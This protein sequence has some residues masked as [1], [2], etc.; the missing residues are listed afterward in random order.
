VCVR[1]VDLLREVGRAV[2]VAVEV[3]CGYRHEERGT[4]MANMTKGRLW[5]RALSAGLLIGG[6]AAMTL[7]TSAA[8]AGTAP[9]V[10]GSALDDGFVRTQGG[11]HLD[12]I[13]DGGTTRPLDIGGSFGVTSD[14]EAAVLNVTATESTGPGFIT[15]YPAFDQAGHAS[16]GNASNVPTASNVNYTAGQIVANEVTAKLGAGGFVC[17]FTYA[18]THIV[19]DLNGYFIKG[20]NYT[21][22]NPARLVDTRPGYPTF[23]GDFAGGGPRPAGGVLELTVTDRG[24][25]GK[26]AKTVILNVTATESTA[27][28]FVTVYPCKDATTP[29]PTSSNV[30]FVAGQTVP[31]TVISKVS[32]EG[33][34]CL[35]T[36]AATHLVVDLN[37]YFPTIATYTPV[38]PVRLLDTRPGYPTFDT[39]FAGAGK[40]GAGGDLVLPVRGLGV[41][42][43]GGVGAD[44]KAVVVNVT[45]TES[46]GPGFLT[47]YPCDTALTEVSNLNY[48]AGTNV[49]NTVFAKVAAD[50]TVCIHTYATTHVVVDL[51]GYFPAS[52]AYQ[53]INPTRIVDTRKP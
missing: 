32:A 17:V 16:C 33:K 2:D 49:P 53:P 26:T 31:N 13:Q 1:G 24:G 5:T 51:E 14:A 11:L 44:A 10:G 28:G 41:A 39:Q 9:A 23:D 22:L 6:A 25:V 35:F 3:T 18:T 47:V 48:A 42:G 50:G 4:E 40:L 46:E 7:T 21:P 36:Y 30:N 8:G 29:P 37:G 20:A 27:P 45:S 43:R 15:V 52:A 12:T 19:I 38:D 34:I